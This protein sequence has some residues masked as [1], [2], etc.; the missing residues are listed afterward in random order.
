MDDERHLEVTAVPASALVAAPESGRPP[1]A[2]RNRTAPAARPEPD[3]LDERDDRDDREQLDELDSGPATGWPTRFGRINGLKVALTLAVA[4][5]LALAGALYV[6]Q[7]Q[8]D[9]EREITAAIERYTAAW[10]AHDVAAVRAAMF[11]NGGIFAAS[12]NI[13]HEAMLVAPWGSELDRTLTALFG[14]D[15]T[16]ETRGRVTIAGDHTRASVLQ[17]FSYTVYGLR[18]VEDG[19]SLYTLSPA[20]RGAGLKVEQHVWWRPRV[21]ASP[22]MLWILDAPTREGG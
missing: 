2:E 1:G 16:L 7:R 11:P 6:T 12:D 4:V 9:D 21:P 8:S 5:A 10:N 20:E 22:S 15:V 18:V 13:T 14:A 3:E 17:R 19:I